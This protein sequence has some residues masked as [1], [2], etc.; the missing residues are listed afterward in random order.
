MLDSLEKDMML[1]LTDG[2]SRGIQCARWSEEIQGTLKMNWHDILAA[3][4]NRAQRKHL[5]Y[6]VVDNRKHQ[7]E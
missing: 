7:Q 3:A 4:Q 2:S 5:I 1:G 6:K